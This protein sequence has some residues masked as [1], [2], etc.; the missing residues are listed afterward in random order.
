MYRIRDGVERVFIT[1]VNNPS[2]SSMAQTQIPVMFDKV[3]VD[4]SEFNHLPGGGN[5]LYMDGHVSYVR[6][7][8][9]FPISRSWG[10]LVDELDF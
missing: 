6:Y 9:A 8:A 2:L 10:E 4:P 1:D 5:V 3:D 7:P